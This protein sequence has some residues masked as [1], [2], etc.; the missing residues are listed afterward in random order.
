[1]P[2]CLLRRI[3]ILDLQSLGNL[4]VELERNISVGGL[5]SI[6]QGRRDS[7]SMAAGQLL[8]FSSVSEGS[9]HDDGVDIVRVVVVEDF[10]HKHHSGVLSWVIVRFPELFLAPVQ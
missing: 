1:M 5:E 7:Q 4:L 8:D 6:K 9:S 2:E 10:S 3:N